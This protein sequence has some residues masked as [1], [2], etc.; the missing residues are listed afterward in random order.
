MKIIYVALILL[1]LAG[2]IPGRESPPIVVYLPTF[3]PTATVTPTLTVTP[4]PTLTPTPAP[5]K[6]PTLT[7]EPWLQIELSI[8]D[9]GT[10]QA[11]AADIYAG[12]FVDDEII[13]ELIEENVSE[14][15]LN[16]PRGL[17]RADVVFINITAEGYR[18]RFIRLPKE[19]KTEPGLTFEVQL[20]KSSR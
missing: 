8:S 9:A 19:A 1:L 14:T 5:T 18:N 15:V 11:V 10:G 17:T 7:P 6:T 12:V 20:E 13:G 4:T 16:L 2:C 3:T